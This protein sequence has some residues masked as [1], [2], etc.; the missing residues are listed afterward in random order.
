MRCVKRSKMERELK[1]TDDTSD[2]YHDY[3]QGEREIIHTIIIQNSKPVVF[4][5]EDFVFPDGYWT[6]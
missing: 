6:I 2:L 4:P 5:D 3:C 1:Y